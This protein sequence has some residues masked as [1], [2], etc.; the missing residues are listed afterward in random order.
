M[1]SFPRE[2]L[3]LRE[4][5][6]EEAVLPLWQRGDVVELGQVSIF[7]THT[8][9]GYIVLLEFQCQWNGIVTVGETIGD[10]KNHLLA[11]FS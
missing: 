2:T 3:K 6:H 1:Q 8:E 10:E 4:A 5:L 9:D 7:N 11:V